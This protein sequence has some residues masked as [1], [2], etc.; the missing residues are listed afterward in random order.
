MLTRILTD[1]SPQVDCVQLNSDNDNNINTNGTT[2]NGTTTNGTSN[3]NSNHRRLDEVGQVLAGACSM[4]ARIA[5]V[6]FAAQVPAEDT[7]EAVSKMWERLLMVGIVGLTKHTSK[8]AA[9]MP[10]WVD[11]CVQRGIKGVE[12]ATVHTLR[13]RPGC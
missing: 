8:F 5:D 4:A 9:S 3:D 12:W 7:R 1:P 10:S 13:T 2:T 11:L 6:V